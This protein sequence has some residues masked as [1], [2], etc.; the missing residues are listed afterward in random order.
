MSHV[1]AENIGRPGG[2]AIPMNTVLQGTAKAWFNLNG[3]GTVAERDSFN[4][5]SYTDNGVGDYTAAFSTA[6]PNANYAMTTGVQNDGAGGAGSTAVTVRIDPT[7]APLAASLR[8][9]TFANATKAD[10]IRFFV[11]LHGD[12]V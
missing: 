9:C 4:V 1:R 3:T 8:H 10:L 2:Q 7:D 6:M 12:P 5:S 11:A